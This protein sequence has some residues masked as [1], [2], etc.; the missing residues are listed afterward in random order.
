[1]EAPY[2]EIYAKSGE[3]TCVFSSGVGNLVMVPVQKYC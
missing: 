1:M 2:R 3:I